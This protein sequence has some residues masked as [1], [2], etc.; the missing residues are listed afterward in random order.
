MM[1]VELAQVT[2]ATKAPI[3]KGGD[4]IDPLK[5]LTHD[6]LVHVL[7][8]CI[9]SGNVVNDGNDGNDCNDSGVEP[10][11]IEGVL[12]SDLLTLV[13][14]LSLLSQEWKRAVIGAIPSLQIFLNADFNAVP[15]NKLDNAIELARLRPVKSIGWLGNEEGPQML[16]MRA[17]DKSQLE[18]AHVGICLP[19]QPNVT[20]IADLE[21]LTF[22]QL[23]IGLEC[24]K[25]KSINVSI[26]LH[27]TVDDVPYRLFRRA[28]FWNSAITDVTMTVDVLKHGSTINDLFFI[29]AAVEDLQSLRRLRLKCSAASISPH[30][31]HNF[32]ISSRSLE[33]LVVNELCERAQIVLD[34]PKLTLFV[35][36]GECVNNATRELRVKQT[37]F[38]LD[39][40]AVAENC[41][42]S[43]RP[44]GQLHEL[45]IP[46]RTMFR[47]ARGRALR[48]GRTLR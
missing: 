10:P 46:F 45:R 33:T 3:Y 39:D 30:P 4:K 47:G 24:P 15:P 18:H 19:L 22:L 11:K 1:S 6:C 38:I 7:S 32:H 34:A 14:M 40:H 23:A 43:C 31:S 17:C 25:I 8:F 41:T 29:S 26:R 5:Y 36:G 37:V 16:R 28:L 21:T 9:G 2:K 13:D 42:V 48:E 35:C 44:F 20:T 27:E 12:L